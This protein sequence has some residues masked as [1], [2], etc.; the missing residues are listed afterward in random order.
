MILCGYTSEKK[1]RAGNTHLKKCVQGRYD[2]G[3]LKQDK[4]TNRA[5]W[6]DNIISYIG[7][8]RWRDKPGSIC[9]RGSSWQSQMHEVTCDFIIVHMKAYQKYG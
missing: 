8:P 7:D 9:S 3:G 5:A 1:K 2:R 6:R 4:T